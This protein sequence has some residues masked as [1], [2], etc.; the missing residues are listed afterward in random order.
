MI[1]SHK[2][3]FVFIKTR[4]TAGSTI[5]SIIFPF[6]GKDD[7]CTGSTRDNT[8][9]LNTTN[10]NGHLRWQYA[11]E[12][13]GKYL[14]FSIERN[15]WDKVVSSFY[16]HKYIKPDVYEKKD[17]DNYINEKSYLPT[18]WDLYSSNDKETVCDFIFQFNHLPDVISFLREEFGMKIKK[19]ILKHVKLKSNIRDNRIHYRNL[20]NENTINKVKLY[21]KKEISYFNYKY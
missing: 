5:E 4:K 8:P 14:F 11:Q 2:Y 3:K 13:L 20:H 17:F 9:N 18:D 10:N 16:F 6:L 7:M 19:D 1:I 21:F 12:F 15:P